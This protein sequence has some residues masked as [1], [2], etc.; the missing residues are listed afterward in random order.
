MPAS[1]VKFRDMAGEVRW[2]LAI[3]GEYRSAPFIKL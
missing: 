2:R 3:R 1:L